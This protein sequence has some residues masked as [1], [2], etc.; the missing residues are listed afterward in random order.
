M[1]EIPKCECG[2]KLE[3]CEFYS[4]IYFNH[5]IRVKNGYNFPKIYMVASFVCDKCGKI[6]FYKRENKEKKI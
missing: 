4:G 5:Q 6:S 1:L 2:G 3:E